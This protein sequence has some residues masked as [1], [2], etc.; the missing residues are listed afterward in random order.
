MMITNTYN[1]D[2]KLIFVLKKVYIHTFNK[3][4]N[5]SMGTRL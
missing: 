1:Y 2:N 5:L 4:L 3:V